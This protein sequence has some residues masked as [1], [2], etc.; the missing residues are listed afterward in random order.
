MIDYIIKPQNC[1]SFLKGY[2]ET[3]CFSHEKKKVSPQI[4]SVYSKFRFS[5]DLCGI[6]TDK[7]N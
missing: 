3:F 5:L 1:F 4:N 2:G 6:I 7:D